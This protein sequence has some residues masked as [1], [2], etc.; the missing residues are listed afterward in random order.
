M[1]FDYRRRRY[2]SILADTHKQ[3]DGTGQAHL[4]GQGRV[5]DGGQFN[6]YHAALLGRQGSLGGAILGSDNKEHG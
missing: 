5:N 6:Q 1:A 3:M 2:A 4:D